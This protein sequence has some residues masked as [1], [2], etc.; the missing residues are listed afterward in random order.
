M[1]KI[2][3]LVLFFSFVSSFDLNCLH[4]Q[5]AINYTSERI[6]LKQYSSRELKRSWI[7]DAKKG[8]EVELN[9]FPMFTI[10]KCVIFN[11]DGSIAVSHYFVFEVENK[12]R[13]VWV[14]DSIFNVDTQ[15]L[16][17]NLSF[18]G[19]NEGN[20]VIN[21]NCAEKVNFTIQFVS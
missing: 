9:I 12:G 21:I 6:I 8:S 15:E 13:F 19:I 14:V 7:L 2:F 16:L 4:I 5:K 1:K 18:E 17:Q 10:S 20:L 11:E 3:L